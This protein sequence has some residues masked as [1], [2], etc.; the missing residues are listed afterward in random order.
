MLSVRF[1]VAKSFVISANVKSLTKF[2]NFPSF[3]DVIVFC[4]F[5]FF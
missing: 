2:E 1:L 3:A 5:V 4:R